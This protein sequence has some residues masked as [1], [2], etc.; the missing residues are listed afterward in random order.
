MEA[1]NGADGLR[2]WVES[3]GHVDLVLTDVVMPDGMSGRELADRLQKGRPQLRVIFTSGYSTDFAGRELA[4]KE[5]QSFLQKPSTPKEILE[6]VR[7]SLDREDARR[8]P[9]VTD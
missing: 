3:G 1:A 5:G 9:I 4:L 2:A 8:P 7:R 6:A